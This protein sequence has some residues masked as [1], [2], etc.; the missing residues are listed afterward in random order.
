MRLTRFFLCITAVA[1]FV[2]LN[3]CKKEDGG[4][5]GESEGKSIV[6]YCSAD[7]EFAQKVVDRFTRKTGIEVLCRYDVE[8]TKTLGLVQRLRSEAGNPQA[9]V[10]WS[11][12]IFETIALANDKILGEYR[13][14]EAQALPASYRDPQGRWY[15]F[16]PRARVIAYNTH[17]VKAAEAPQSIED[18]LNPCWKKKLV[19]ARPQFGTTRG[20]V[21]AWWVHYGPE[22]AEAI[23]AGLSANEV[24]VVSGN[25]TAVRTVAEGRAAVCLTDTDDVWV[26]QRNGWPVE[27][28]YPKHGSAGTLMIPNT[29]AMVQ[30]TKKP[31]EAG[32]FIDFMLSEEVERMLAESDSHNIPLR[33][34]LAKEYAKYAVP[35]PMTI[36]YAEVARAIGPAMRAAGKMGE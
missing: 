29:V 26:A 24:S 33:P 7:Q 6:V 28:V 31:H 3:G 27:L 12:E 23:L 36:D 21:A 4:P 20:H 14:P 35:S 19:I 30:G 9:D 13:S 8:A 25:S 5:A 1:G 11:S 18:L 22:K 17:L 15:G 16:A 10:F 2:F 34:E 32:M